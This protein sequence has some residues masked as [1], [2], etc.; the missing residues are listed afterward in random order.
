MD[1]ELAMQSWGTECESLLPTQ[2]LSRAMNIISITP[3]LEAGAQQVPA[4]MEDP[5]SKNKVN[6]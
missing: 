1:K 6:H 5:V 4:P 3:V 2:N